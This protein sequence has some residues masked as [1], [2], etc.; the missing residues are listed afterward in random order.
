VIND[1]WY[2]E[3][4]AQR[5]VDFIGE[6]QHVK[7]RLIGEKFILPDWQEQITRDIFGWKRPDG[8]RRYRT[9]YLEIPRKQGK[10]SLAAA[11]ALV[12]LLMDQPPGRKMTGPQRRSWCHV[13]SAAGTRDQAMSVFAPAMQMLQ[14]TDIAK[15]CIIRD[16]Y[17]RISYAGG[18]YKALSADASN[19]HGLHPS[20][21]IFDELHVQPDRNLWDALQTGRGASVNPLTICLTT[22][23]TDKSSICFEM[24]QRAMLWE[25]AP[26]NDPSF[27]AAVY[28]AEPSDDWTD[29]KVWRKAN[30]N[31]GVTVSEEFLQEECDI[32]QA[33]E[34]AANTFKRLYLNI[35]TRTQELAINME[36]WKACRGEVDT[37]GP[38][39][40]GIDLASTKDITAAV[41]VFPQDNGG[42]GVIP[43]FWA[44]RES[45]S[46]R[47]RQ[48]RRKMMNYAIQT[49]E[50]T[51]TDGNVLDIE[52]LVGDI[53]LFLQ[54]YDVQGVGFD[55]WNA[56]AVIQILTNQMGFDIGRCYKL[57]QGYDT[58]NQPFKRLKEDLAAGKFVHPGNIVLSWMAENTAQK[59]DPSGNIRPNKG[60]SG[61]KI[62]GISATLMGLA[63]AIRK[64]HA[65]PSPYEI[66]GGGMLMF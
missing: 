45:V 24:H 15:D 42:Y 41:A 18:F 63:L 16:S 49:G 26:D 39:F 33:Q 12:L 7:G 59:E 19:A 30:P 32:A 29:P 27:Y 8:T 25:K 61:D 6:L 9:V 1:Y 52:Y 56:E 55:P 2:D 13:Y 31:L 40:V 21:I 35:W 57:K 65:S 28:R 48:D 58:Y 4:A 14:Q 47:A 60:A 62:D 10:S 11:Y 3:E 37:S 22:A 36:Q 20:G 50:I 51:L 44:P 5:V 17:K 43:R 53:F 38:C 64:G 66:D 23:G 54:Q 46:E 34:G